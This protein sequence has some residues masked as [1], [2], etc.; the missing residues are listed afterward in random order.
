MS[1]TTDKIQQSVDRLKSA[2]ELVKKQVDNNRLL[3]KKEVL[4]NNC[5]CEVSLIASGLVLINFVELESAEKFY[6]EL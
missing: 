3:E 6:N 4:I 1:E 2:I 5:K